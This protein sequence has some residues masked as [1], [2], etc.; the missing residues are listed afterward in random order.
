MA[1]PRARVVLTSRQDRAWINSCEKVLADS[2]FDSVEAYSCWSAEVARELHGGEVF[3][4]DGHILC[5]FISPERPGPVLALSP[6]V[7]VVI[8]NAQALDEQHRSAAM[9]HNALIL[10]G[11]DFAEIARAVVSALPPS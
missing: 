10:D 11:E 3:V 9:S 8:F 1:T 2:G 5:E 7:P 6:K 4:I